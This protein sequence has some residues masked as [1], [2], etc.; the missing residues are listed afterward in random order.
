MVRIS[1]TRAPA[2]FV[3]LVRIIFT[4]NVVATG[5][6]LSCQTEERFSLCNGPILRMIL[7]ICCLEPGL[8]SRWG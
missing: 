2:G 7:E 1:L 3:R 5:D 4:F 8:I 6:S